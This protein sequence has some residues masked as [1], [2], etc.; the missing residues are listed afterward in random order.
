MAQETT[1]PLDELLD[2]LENE[3]GWTCDRANLMEVAQTLRDAQESVFPPEEVRD[4]YGRAERRLYWT[5]NET[6]E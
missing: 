4:E 6:G 3:L 2:E 1:R 5:D